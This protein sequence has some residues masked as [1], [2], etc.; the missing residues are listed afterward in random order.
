MTWC[1]YC[2]K[3]VDTLCR[4]MET[5]TRGN[6]TRKVGGSGRADPGVVTDPVTGLKVSV[7]VLPAPAI[8]SDADLKKYGYAPGHYTGKCRM[9]T[10]IVAGVDKC[11]STCRDCAV[12]AYYADKAN[13]PKA[14]ADAMDAAVNPPHVEAI[15]GYAFNPAKVEMVKVDYDRLLRRLDDADTRVRDLTHDLEMEKSRNDDLQREH[16]EMH[17]RQGEALDLAERWKADCLSAWA[18]ITVLQKIADEA[19]RATEYERGLLQT[20]FTTARDE[21]AVHALKTNEP[22]ITHYMLDEGISVYTAMWKARKPKSKE[23]HGT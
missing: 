4:D 20:L 11:V 14:T 2:R 3:N 21:G 9:C 23:K 17:K 16:D 8:V 18:R 12:K 10:Q 5:C 19:Q 1:E 6:T 22:I 15:A 7:E 13:Y